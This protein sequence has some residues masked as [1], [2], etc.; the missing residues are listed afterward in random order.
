MLLAPSTTDTTSATN[1]HYYHHHHHHYTAKNWRGELAKNFWCPNRIAIRPSGS[2]EA[3]ERFNESKMRYVYADLYRC[4]C[5]FSRENT[6]LRVRRDTRLHAK[7]SRW[8]LV[9]RREQLI[10]SHVIIFSGCVL[11]ICTFVD[12]HRELLFFFSLS[13]SPIYIYLVFFRIC[14]CLKVRSEI[15][16]VR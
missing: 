9:T 4:T 14:Y 11:F 5:K 13:L 10:A 1:H 7:K 8:L 3:N 12:K 15:Q 6:T 2:G 16:N